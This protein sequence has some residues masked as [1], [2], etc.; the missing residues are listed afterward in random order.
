MSYALWLEQGRIRPHELKPADLEGRITELW[1]A[2][3]VAYGDGQAPGQSVD[4]RFQDAYAALRHLAEIV[5]AAEG[6]RPASGPGQHEILFAFLSEVPAADWKPWVGYFQ[7]CRRRR[8]QAA[9]QR[10]GLITRK[11][12]ED[13]LAEVGHFAQEVR[14]WLAR[15]HPGLPR[16]E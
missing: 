15:R 7:R 13:L 1:S 16:G 6:Y 9:Y 14:A 10:S 12:L 8:S 3:A 5:M 2:F 4:G 11:E